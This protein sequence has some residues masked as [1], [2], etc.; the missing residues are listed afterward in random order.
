MVVVE[1]IR[2]EVTDGGGYVARLRDATTRDQVGL[3]H[4]SLVR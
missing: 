1:S 2:V 3:D 4:D